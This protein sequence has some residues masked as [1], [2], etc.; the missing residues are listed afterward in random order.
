MLCSALLTEDLNS[1]LSPS[2]YPYLTCLTVMTATLILLF[3]NPIQAT[4]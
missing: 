3:L 1:P 2:K 4:F